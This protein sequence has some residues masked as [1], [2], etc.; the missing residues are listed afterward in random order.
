MKRD[1]KFS[2]FLLLL[3]FNFTSILLPILRPT[4]QTL[5][6]PLRYG[7][8]ETDT[9]TKSTTTH[10]QPPEPTTQ[11]HPPLS[12]SCSCPASI[13][14]QIL[15]PSISMF[16][17][18]IPHLLAQPA[19]PGYITSMY[20]RFCPPTRHDMTMSMHAGYIR[21]SRT[22]QDVTETTSNRSLQCP[23][24]VPSPSP[25]PCLSVAQPKQDART[26][27]EKTSSLR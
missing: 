8:R 6:R 11:Q 20:H 22:A 14:I 13:L 25:P 9:R 10:F 7:S 2:C 1:S 17:R 19:H 26:S 12:F 23:T 24:N 21:Q 15:L 27:G 18:P 3:S 16:P 5:S 4:S